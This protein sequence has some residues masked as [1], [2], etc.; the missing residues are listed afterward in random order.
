MFVASKGEGPERTTNQLCVVLPDASDGQYSLPAHTAD[1]CF[2]K[3]IEYCD[4][5]Y[6]IEHDEDNVIFPIER[7][8]ITFDIEEET[9]VAVDELVFS[10][11]PD[12]LIEFGDLA[13]TYADDNLDIV[14]ISPPAS[15]N[16][17][18][19]FD[20][21]FSEIDD[22]AAVTSTWVLPGTVTGASKTVT[23][24]EPRFI[25]LR[26]LKA[27]RLVSTNMDS[28]HVRDYPIS[29]DGTGEVD[30]L[31]SSRCSDCQICLEWR[32]EDGRLQLVQLDQDYFFHYRLLH[33]SSIESLNNHDNIYCGLDDDDIPYPVPE[34]ILIDWPLPCLPVLFFG[35]PRR[36]RFCISSRNGDGRGRLLRGFG[37]EK[38]TEI[39]DLAERKFPGIPEWIVRKLEAISEIVLTA[40]GTGAGS[41]CLPTGGST[42]YLDNPQIEAAQEATPRPSVGRKIL[43]ERPRSQTTERNG[44]RSQRVEVDLAKR[45]RKVFR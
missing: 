21:G 20:R 5:T 25:E 23:V 12:S 18:V 30:I 41:D 43:A 22:H 38:E 8:R 7:S 33:P 15:V 19:V 34:R 27:I 14:A 26:N 13:G 24:R 1:V 37:I 16:G 36:W 40:V 6:R 39:R 35:G 31:V 29:D 11:S 3:R 28:D 32:L 4:G 17:Q 9:S 2:P 45:S 42:R 44:S 10:Y